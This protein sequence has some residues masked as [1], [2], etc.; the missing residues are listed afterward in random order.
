MKRLVVWVEGDRDRRFFEAVVTPRLSRAHDIVLVKP[1]RHLERA[2]TNQRLRSMSQE[3]FDRLFV[4]DLNAAPCVTSRKSKLKEHYTELRDEEI[5]VVSKEIESWYLA[6]LTTEG[7]AALKVKCP[8]STDQ[9]TKEE[10]DRIR[11]S[12]FDVQLDFL[13]ELL[14]SFDLGTACRRNQSFAY[15]YRKF[16]V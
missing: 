5:I 14:R 4:A 12:R 3:G 2:I 8:A 13:L 10:C 1:Y 15:F 7:A 6:G 16:L 9:L 11:P